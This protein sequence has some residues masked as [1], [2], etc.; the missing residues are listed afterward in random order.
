MPGLWLFHD[1][2]KDRKCLAQS[3]EKK[4]GIP[5]RLVLKFI[6]W[7]RA[8]MPHQDL[9]ITVLAWSDFITGFVLEKVDRY[10]DI[11]P[12]QNKTLEMV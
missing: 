11:Q 6:P 12:K 4:I 3:V 9:I 1:L 10:F 5:C 8:T 2:K 7:H